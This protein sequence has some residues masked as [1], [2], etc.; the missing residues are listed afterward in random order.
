[1]PLEGSGGEG[2]GGEG[3]REGKGTIR[4]KKGQETL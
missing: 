4:H 1:M 3:L 2:E